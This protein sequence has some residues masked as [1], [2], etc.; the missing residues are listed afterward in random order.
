MI[1]LRAVDLNLLP[2][3]EAVY[4]ER[5]MTRAAHRLAMSQP[6]VSNAV[7]R[8]RA[9]MR[10]ELFVAG[11]RGTVVTPM[12]EQVYPHVKSALDIVRSGLGERRNFIPKTSER[13]FSL[14]LLYAPGMALGRAIGDWLRREAPRLSSRLVQVDTRDEGYAGLREGRLDL[15]L[16]HAKPSA[17]DLEGAVLFNDELL[18][19]ASSR[20]PRL[21]DTL[22][23]REF[24]AERHVVHRS[25]RMPGNFAHV[26][27]AVG[28]HDIDVAIEARGP[29]ELPIIVAGTP[30]I[31]VCNR[32]LAEPWVRTLGLKLLPLPFRAPALKGWLV[33]HASRRRDAGHQWVRDGLVVQSRLFEQRTSS[34]EVGVAA[35]RRARR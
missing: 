14:G 20:H 19:I 26:E 30:Y 12:A 9:A 24:L 4:E 8:L 28:G 6:A 31:A 17:R 3:F 21:A 2:V 15:L 5:N 11:R 1:N 35:S 23:R 29:L 27:G 16:D 7:A 13:R 10:D 22:T 32:K 18:V 33:W 34:R 25:L